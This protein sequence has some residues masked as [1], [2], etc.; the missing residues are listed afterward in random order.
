MIT[1]GYVE[2]APFFCDATETAKD[3]VNNTMN[4]IMNTPEHPL[5]G[6]LETPTETENQKAQEATAIAE[7]AWHRISLQVQKT[8]LD[9]IE[10]YLNNFI[11]VTH[12]GPSEQRQMMLRLFRPIDTLLRPKKPLD[13]AMRIPYF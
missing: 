2:S 11:G 7:K 6:I 8:V 1:M 12:G 10:V 3:M 4:D 9:H 5:E 13:V